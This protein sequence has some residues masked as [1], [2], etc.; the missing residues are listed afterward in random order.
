VQI[1]KLFPVKAFIY[2]DFAKQASGF[3]PIVSGWR[4]DWMVPSKSFDKLLLGRLGR[5]SAAFREHHS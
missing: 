2:A 5:S 4:Q 1:A 3:E